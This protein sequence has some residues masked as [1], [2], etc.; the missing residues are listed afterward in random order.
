MAVL[1]VVVI[2]GGVLLALGLVLS[3][4]LLP[5]LVHPSLDR[6]ILVAYALL[7]VGAPCFALGLAGRAR[8]RQ[9]CEV[10]IDSSEVW[11][12]Y[13]RGENAVLRWDD[14]GLKASL[15][16]VERAPRVDGER[17]PGW[18]LSWRGRGHRRGA[19]VSVPSEAGKA[20]A[21][22][23]GQLDLDVETIHREMPS[24]HGTAKL[25]RTLIRSR[26]RQAYRSPPRARSP[27]SGFSGS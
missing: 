12:R 19:F 2:A 16:H 21:R 14:V 18:V 26:R 10:T 27:P 6:R 24:H 8:V 23:A 9:L 15:T 17:P 1:A 11:L 13:N 20:I 25:E 4:A 7:I 5:A 3:F 22:R